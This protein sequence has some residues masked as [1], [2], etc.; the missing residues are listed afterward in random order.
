MTRTHMSVLPPPSVDGAL[1]ELLREILREELPAALRAVIPTL[2]DNPPETGS[3]E[4]D[5][6]LSIED[7]ARILAVHPTTVRRLIR[8]GDLRSYGT[9]RLGRVRRRHLDELMERANRPK[10]VVDTGEKARAM[11]VRALRRKGKEGA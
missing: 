10:L 7:A 3:T 2:V 9:G 11:L 8:R 6:Y 5:T 1:R 4:P